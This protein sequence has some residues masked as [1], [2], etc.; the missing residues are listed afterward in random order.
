MF[1]IPVGRKMKYGLNIGSGKER[2][3][4]DLTMEWINIDADSKMEPDIVCSAEDLE[5]LHIDGKPFTEHFDLIIAKDILEHIPYRED[6]KDRWIM[7]LSSWV[8]CLKP[9]G[10]IRIQVPDPFA[11]ADCLQRGTV[12]EE[13][14]N[15][16]IFGESTGL[17]D[18]HYQLISKNRLAMAMSRCR[19]MITK[20][21]TLHVCAIV[22]GVNPL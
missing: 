1:G 7:C 19:L 21:E 14:A 6:D 17:L 2:K 5:G 11:I 10:T 12:S 22:E 20:M 16:V 4:N 9:G 18:H 8:R 3:I 13:T 15:R